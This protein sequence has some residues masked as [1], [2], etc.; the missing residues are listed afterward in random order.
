M[1]SPDGTY[2]LDVEVPKVDE[3]QR[4]ET[5]VAAYSGNFMLS[6]TGLDVYNRV[7][8]CRRALPGHGDIRGDERCSLCRRPSYRARCTSRD[9]H[10]PL[11]SRHRKTTH[12]VAWDD[13]LVAIHSPRAPPPP[14]AAERP[15]RTSTATSPGRLP[16]VRTSFGRWGS[17]MGAEIPRQ[18]PATPS[19]R[20]STRCAGYI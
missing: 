15:R 10:M 8:D 2:R 5:S 12:P 4:V 17:R 18:R 14:A 3:V 9:L 6:F 7:V 19:C 11:A 20:F 13:R 16:M 1:R